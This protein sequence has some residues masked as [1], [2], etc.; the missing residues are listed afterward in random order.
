AWSLAGDSALSSRLRRHLPRGVRK[1]LAPKPTPS[2]RMANLPNLY[3][4]AWERPED[5]QFLKDKKVG[6]AFLAQTVYLMPSL[7]ASSP[8]ST[9][10]DSSFSDAARVNILP[11]LQPLRINPGSPL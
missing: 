10:P 6:V 4:W 5:L 7:A 9:F 8:K 1:F 2:P 3:L 11:R